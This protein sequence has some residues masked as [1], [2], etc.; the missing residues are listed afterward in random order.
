MLTALCCADPALVFSELMGNFSAMV[1]NT[2]FNFN[3]GVIQGSEESLSQDNRFL[4]K[5]SYENLSHRTQYTFAGRRDTIHSI[6]MLYLKQKRRVNE[7]DAA[8]R[9][10]LFSRKSG[11][12]TNQTN[13]THRV[14]NAIQ[15]YG[16]SG[17]RI[18]YLY[19]F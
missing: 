3:L 8:D 15:D 19:E 13:R 14:L 1:T 12:A 7:Y 11:I 4:D 18:D 9:Y 16:V 2:I 10:I 6:F 17:Q 5:T